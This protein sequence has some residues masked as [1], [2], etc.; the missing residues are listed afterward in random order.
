MLTPTL[1]KRK[2]NKAFS[3]QKFPT[4]I[5]YHTLKTQPINTLQDEH[6]LSYMNSLDKNKGGT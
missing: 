3:T 2:N 6:L 5:T 4:S 1:S